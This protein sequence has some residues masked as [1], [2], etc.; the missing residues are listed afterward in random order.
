MPGKAALAAGL[1]A[2]RLR[3]ELP[4]RAYAVL[5]QA[6]AQLGRLVV[7]TGSCRQSGFTMFS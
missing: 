1:R 3:Q 7:G 5:Q 4:Q 6:R 2:E